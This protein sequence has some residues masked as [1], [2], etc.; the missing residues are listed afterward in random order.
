MERMPSSGLP[1]DFACLDGGVGG[2]RHREGTLCLDGVVLVNDAV[3]DDGVRNGGESI[4]VA[5][6]VTWT[7]SPSFLRSRAY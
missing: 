2:H 4:V 1:V 6:S 3:M 7:V 5:H